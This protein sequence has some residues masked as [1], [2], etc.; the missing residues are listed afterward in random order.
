MERFITDW[1]SE[2]PV[3]VKVFDNNQIFPKRI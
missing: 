1:K 2:T 3:N